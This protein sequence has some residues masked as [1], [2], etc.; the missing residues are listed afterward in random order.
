[1]F[2]N[3]QK[4]KW[5]GIFKNFTCHS[6]TGIAPKFNSASARVLTYNP[7]YKYLTTLRK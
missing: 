7:N 2:E 3:Y 6:N 1:M 5:H 4:K